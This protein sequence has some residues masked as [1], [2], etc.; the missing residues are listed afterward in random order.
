MGV[1]LNKPSALPPNGSASG[2]LGGSYPS[3]TVKQVHWSVKALTSSDS[4][5]TVAAADS[6]LKC[7]AT[8]ATVTINLPAATGSGREIDIKKVDSSANACAPT[9]SGTD[10]IDGVNAAIS[11]IVQNVNQVLIDAASGAWQKKQIVSLGGDL[12]GAS[13]NATVGKVNNGAIPAS[14]T[15]VGTDSNARIVDATSAVPTALGFTP[16]PTTTTVNSHPLSSNVTVTQSDLSAYQGRQS[17]TLVPGGGVGSIGSPITMLAS[18][19]ATGLYAVYFHVAQT[20]GGNCTTAGTV[21]FLVAYT[22]ADSNGTFVISSNPGHWQIVGGGGT[23]AVTLTMATTFN[24]VNSVGG[25]TPVLYLKTGTALVYQMY[26]AIQP[27]GGTCDTP[28]QFE[29]TVSVSRLM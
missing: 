29:T 22:D 11:M 28:A 6:I 12:S 23:A 26:Q 1:L 24:T 20:V 27:S 2:D 10:T 19:L 5:Y 21:E 14:K 13:N 16:V 25:G 15:L 3:P 17:W 18:G 4:P 7:D 8:A 9:P